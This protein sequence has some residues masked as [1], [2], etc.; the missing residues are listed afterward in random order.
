MDRYNNN[1]DLIWEKAIIVPG[2]DPH[3]FR[4][5]SC[6][7]WIVK[8]KYN[9]RD[10]DFGWEVDHIYPQAKLKEKGATDNEIDTLDNL[11]P[12]NW[13]NNLSK[14]TDYPIY[15]A[16]VTA[17]GNTNTV[18]EDKYEINKD[19]QETIKKIYSKYL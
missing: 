3:K 12:L 1:L 5:D 16:N 7:A 11:R 9:D 17:E 6:G 18:K 13:H 14:G 2:Y 15:S 19:T 4:K 10:S 8:D